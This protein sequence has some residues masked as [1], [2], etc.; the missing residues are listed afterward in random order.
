MSGKDKPPLPMNPD[1]LDGE[2]S[3]D[4]AVRASREK[5]SRT[6]LRKL[7]RAK[8]RAE[9]KRGWAK[10][11]ASRADTDTE[12]EHFED[13]GI[14]AGATSVMITNLYEAHLTSVLASERVPTKRSPDWLTQLIENYLAQ[15]QDA[16]ENQIRQRLKKEPGVTF[17]TDQEGKVWICRGEQEP[18]IADSALKDRIS[19]RRSGKV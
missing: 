18:R 17:Q 5:P 3:R 11:E 19:R 14:S 13:R 6:T 4:D 7:D 2:P 8:Q 9:Q 12:R 1:W 10:T 15:D 16:D